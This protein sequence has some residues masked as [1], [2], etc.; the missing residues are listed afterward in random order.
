MPLNGNQGTASGCK[1]RPF[2]S[3]WGI[4]AANGNV[5]CFDRSPDFFIEYK[6]RIFAL[7]GHR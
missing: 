2:R 4:G 1:S 3:E 7:G 6:K 5:T